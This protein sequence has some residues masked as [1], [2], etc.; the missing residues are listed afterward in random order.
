MVLREQLTKEYV[1]LV[2]NYHPL[3]GKIL[4]LCYVKILD[5]YQQRARKYYYY[6]VIYYPQEKFEEVQAKKEAFQEIA[7]NMGLIEVVYINAD[8]LIRDPMSEIKRN[9]PRF[10]LELYWIATQKF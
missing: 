4:D 5:C 10:W 3:A 6:I 1:Q 2:N 7:E 8:R 9:N